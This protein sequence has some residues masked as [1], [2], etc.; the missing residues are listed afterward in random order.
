[1]KWVYCLRCVGIPKGFSDAV[2]SKPSWRFQRNSLDLERKLKRRS[3]RSPRN[4]LPMFS[5]TPPPRTPRCGCK[6]LTAGFPSASLTTGE[7]FLGTWKPCARE[8]TASA[9]L[10]SN[11]ACRIMVDS[12]F[13]AAQTPAP[14]SKS[15][16]Q[17]RARA[18]NRSVLAA[19]MFRFVFAFLC[20]IKVW[21][22]LIIR[23]FAGTLR[24][25]EYRL[26]MAGY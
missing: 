8:A 14:W 4:R 17:L 16:F 15:R 22:R 5:G 9:S 10:A 18:V 3:L 1:M 6:N 13:F 26:V 11:S 7:V 12:S 2:E 20:D 25:I 21:Q 23:K 24:H 19:Q